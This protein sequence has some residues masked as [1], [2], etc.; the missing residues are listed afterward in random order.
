MNIYGDTGN[1]RTL[2]YRTSQRSINVKRIACDIGDKISHDVDIIVTGGG[3]DSGQFVIQDDLLKR[4]T[5]LTARIDDGVVLLTICG[6]YQLFGHRFK[7]SSGE[8]IRGISLFDLETKGSEERFIGNV[9]IATEFGTMVGFENHSG[10]TYLASGQAKFGT[11]LKGAGNNGETGDEG[12]IKN[13]AFGT[14]MHGPV[15]PK[16]PRFADELIRRALLRKYGSG[17]EQL[18]KSLDDLEEKKASNIAAKLPR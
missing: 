2:E 10:K 8:V 13:N 4:K 7:T 16:N 11:V 14:Y 5:D 6:T 17:S 12:A 18:L 1:V 3:Q 15:L 9:T